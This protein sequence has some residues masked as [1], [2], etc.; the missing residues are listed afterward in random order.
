M[1]FETKFRKKNKGIAASSV[2]T[3]LAN[4]RRL[5]KAMGFDKIPETGSWIKTKKLL[6]WLR[7]QNLNTKKILSSAG[8]KA[9][10]TY[11]EGHAGLGKIMKES[12]EKYETERGKQ[13]KTK[14]EKVLMP[15]GG[16]AAVGKAAAKLRAQLP[17][18]VKTM[19]DY[20]QLQDAWLL[21]FFG[22]HTPRLIESVLIGKG[23]NR[24]QSAGKGWKITLGEHKTSKSRGASV[25]K[26]DKSLNEITSRLIKARLPQ[27]KHNFL[28]S[29]ARGGKMSKSGLS[30][31]LT[32][33]T[34]KALGRGFNSQILR[35]LK[36][37]SQSGIMKKVKE[38]LDEMGHGLSQERK[39]VAK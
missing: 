7:K 4:I 14:R 8:V 9:A 1:T 33:I 31:R 6:T 19:R 27:I 35:V 16:Y 23:T 11:G 2:K 21:S 24:I 20:M 32:K 26:L 36:A 25:I 39:Y 30:Q 15:D 22:K 5:A 12:S 38:Y 29:A 10:Q 37:T 28:L 18:K 13:K 3:Y 17:A 34:A